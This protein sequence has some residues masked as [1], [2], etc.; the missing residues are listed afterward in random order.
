VSVAAFAKRLA[1]EGRRPW[2]LINNA[3]V[4]LR[5]FDAAVAARTLEVNHFGAARMTDA[6]LPGLAAGARVVMVS[7]GMGELGSFAPALRARFLDPGLDREG[8]D[9]L[10]QAFLDDV[11]RGEHQ[12]RGWPSNAYRVSKALM[13]ALVRVLAPTLSRRGVLVNAV[14]PGWVRTEL[15]GAAAPRSV[16]Q[17]AASVVTTVMLPDDG[18]TGGFF[19]DGRAISW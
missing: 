1:D 9:Q 8:V 11:R 15:G 12:Q 2:A 14:C 10:A 17:G 6:L 18:P 19:R 5:G 4:S 16:A 3:G 13:N 7:S